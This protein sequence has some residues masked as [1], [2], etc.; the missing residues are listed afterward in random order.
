[1]GEI[2][3]LITSVKSREGFKFDGEVAKLI[4][5]DPRELATHKS[6]D[7]LP[8]K[9]QQWY[10][11]YYDI[12][13]KKFKTEIKLTNTDIQL[14]GASDMDA[15]YVI[16]LQKDK[17]ETQA[18]E[19]KS[20]KDALKKKQAE[21]THWE[22]LE[23]DYIAETTLIRERFELGRIIERV[24]DLKKQSDVLGYSEKELLKMWDV[25][26]KH[27]DMKD[28]PI[29]KIINAETQLEIKKQSL[30]LPIIFDALK[31]SV[32]DHYIPQPIIYIHKK[33]HNVGAIAYCKVDWLKM[34]VVAKVQF[35]TD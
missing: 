34:K 29:E 15:Q 33:G 28:H 10:C 31:S 20:L 17:I 2:H 32:G 26:V 16:D 25:G 13:R 8:A 24:T 3:N 7:N 21:S 22:S 1:M 18:I 14:K 12:E 5:I 23:F 6:R 27:I 4:G 30:T 11:D 19:I 9:L 35:L